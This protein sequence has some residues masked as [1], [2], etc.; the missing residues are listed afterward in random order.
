M[1][2]LNKEIQHV[3]NPAFGAYIIWN[4]VR[5]YYSNNSSFVPFPLLF[6]V[7]PIIFREDMVEQINGTQKASG[8]RQFS[9]KF[10]STKVLK[11]DVISQ[12]HISSSN[13]KNLTLNSIRVSIYASL[14]SLD[15]EN[16]LAL[17]IS[18]TERKNEPKNILKLGKASEKLG[19]WCSQLTLHEVSQIMKVRF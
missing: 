18:M 3:Q 10:L 19:Y 14:I 6:V 17:P 13:M 11:N 15:Y 16:A 1:S 7:L 5:G 12:I 4:F 9:N 2:Q 8:L